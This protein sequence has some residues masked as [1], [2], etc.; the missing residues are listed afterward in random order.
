MLVLPLYL[1]LEEIAPLHYTCMVA[2]DPPKLWIIPECCTDHRLNSLQK[3][4]ESN[5]GLHRRGNGDA[6]LPQLFIST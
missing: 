5:C 2:L 1:S 6:P 3:A 4:L